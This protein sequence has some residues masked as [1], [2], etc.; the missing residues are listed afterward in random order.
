MRRI[1]IVAFLAWA[2]IALTLPLALSW[3]GRGTAPQVENRRPSAFPTEVRPQD[4]SWFSGVT[5]Y[6]E[7]R[8]S[9]AG[10]ATRALR[11]FDL[12]V[13]RR[14]PAGDVLVGEGPW[15]FVKETLAAPCL[16]EQPLDAERAILERLRRAA[17]S[18]GIRVVL[19]VVPDK[20][21]MEPEHAPVAFRAKAECLADR[22]VESER[23]A[24]SILGAD[25]LPVTDLLDT[26]PTSFHPMDSHWTAR[27]R[28]AFMRDLVGRLQPGMWS[29]DAVD[30]VQGRREMDLLALAGIPRTLD[31]D[32]NAPRFAAHT[33]VVE[34]STLPRTA[35]ISGEAAPGR[36]LIEAS[37]LL[38]HDSF[39]AGWRDEFTA[40][41]A[42][43][44]VM[45]WNDLE[46]PEAA[47]LLLAHD[48]VV[49]ETVGR[50]YWGESAR[51]RQ[52][53]EILEA[54]QDGVAQPS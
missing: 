52:L 2:M 34:S 31:V 23:L 47:K 8:L 9:F 45:H 40:L 19:S 12:R 44:T 5:Q 30:V 27:G 3:T 36:Q 18:R 24:A 35:S 1:L 48:V 4:A 32:A 54:G 14:L 20:L 7:D 33:S 28:R 15:L 22:A 51:L 37:A 10:G 25:V 16:A 39:V 21:A 46:D 17:A 53:V 43:G 38:L 6:V 29:D 26:E 50:A 11:T 41:F 49:L 13:T 42:H